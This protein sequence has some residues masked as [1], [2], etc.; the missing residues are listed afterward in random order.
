MPSRPQVASENRLLASLPPRDRKRILAACESVQLGFAEILAEP[1]ERIH[2]VYFPTRSFIS[3]TA[4]TDVH[5]DLEV[6]LIGDE[7]MLG[8]SLLLGVDVSPLH[9]LVQG[10][11]A[12]LRLDATTLRHE[13][14][15]SGALDRILRRYLYIMLCQLAQTATCN[16]FHLLEARLARWLLMTRDRAHADTFHIT[17]DFLAYMLGVRRVGITKAAGSLQ[18]Q[19]LIRYHRGD[20]VI[21]DLSGLQ[22]AACACYAIDRNTYGRW[23]S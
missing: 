21:L 13:L 1:G 17:H 15:R 5:G 12:A 9:A 4:P 3:L 8:A 6:G 16:R 11:G 23:L 22:S 20:I 2:H 7:G 18:Q 19:S 10:A 14:K